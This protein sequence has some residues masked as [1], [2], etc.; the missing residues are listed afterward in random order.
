ME[1]KKKKKKKERNKNNQI[2]YIHLRR[3]KQYVHIK[4]LSQMSMTIYST[5]AKQETTQV[6]MKN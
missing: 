5:S 4:T 6:P 2:E 1:R 3:M